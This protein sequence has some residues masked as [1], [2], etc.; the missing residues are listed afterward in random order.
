MVPVNTK[1]YYL[2]I[3]KQIYR[4]KLIPGTNKL[5][6]ELYDNC[7]SIGKANYVLA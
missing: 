6:I 2:P 1:S 7:V 3:Y 4:L 5:C